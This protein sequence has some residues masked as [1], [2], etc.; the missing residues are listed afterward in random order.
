VLAALN[1][2]M[3]EV[4]ADMARRRRRLAEEEAKYSPTQPRVPA[5]NPRGGRWTDRSGGSGQSP[6][7]SLAQPMGNVDVGNLSGSSEREGLFNIAPG[8]T[9]HMGALTRLADND[10]TPQLI[11]NANPGD[12]SENLDD[13][14]ARRGGASNWF[15]GASAGQQ[16]RL[17]Q[18]IARSEN[19]LTQIR[20][21]DPD[22][23]PREQSLTRPGSVDGAIARLEARA[24]EAE[25]RPDQLRT[26]IG[27]NRGPSLDPSPRGAPLSPRVFDGGAWIDAYRTINNAPDLFGRPSWP[28]D[29]G[30]VAVGK[31]DGQVYFGVNS[32]APGYS[33]TDWNRARM[34]RDDLIQK[35]PDTMERTNIGWA[36]NDALFHAESTILLRAAK[37]NG[38]SLANRSM[39][40]Y[41][42]R[43]VCSSCG[44]ALT[45]LG[46]ELGNPYVVY[47]ER[48]TRLRHE[49]WN[50]EWLSGRYK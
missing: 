45:K 20:Q 4:H 26:G 34:T 42:D 12:D 22:W 35:Y 39:E 14:N 18:A 19:A 47:V 36:P 11:P 31:I 6:S 5:G 17:D 28:Q 33:G 7:S 3:K 27:G 50:G 40:I 8:G 1:E 48:D 30:T 16:S 32:D 13:V 29:K 46:L 37:D 25:T 44:K 9:E 15:P 10:S 23:Q 24:P 21:Y 38:G 49:M 41:V 2:E 43:E